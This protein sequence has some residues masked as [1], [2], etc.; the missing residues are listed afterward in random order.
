MIS[1]AVSDQMGTKQHSKNMSKRRSL[2][3]AVSKGGSGAPLWKSLRELLPMF[4]Q[5][6]VSRRPQFQENPPYP[7]LF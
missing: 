1:Y 4:V 7:A 2:S 5:C 3:S 6:E